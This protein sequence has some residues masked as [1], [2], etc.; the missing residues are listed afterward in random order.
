[1]Q[2]LIAGLGN[3]GPEYELTPHNL[4]FLVIDRL[5]ERN[6]IRVSRPD[7]K[8]L[9]G[10]GNIGGQPVLLA[11]PQTFM[12]LSGSSVKGLLVKH[13]IPVGNLIVVCD[14]MNLPWTGVRVRPNGSAGGQNGMKSVIA[15]LGGGEF[16][17]VRLGVNPGTP[18]GDMSQFLLSPMR[19]GQLEELDEVLDHAAA[20]VE[21]IIADGVEMSMTR[22]NRRARGLNKEEA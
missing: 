19:R 20:A 9:V 8:A 17:R 12:N 16:S 7:S 21:S 5:A 1:M 15:S 13:E 3:P 18:V 4:G 11:K 22:F 14:E 2:W 10:T 6:G